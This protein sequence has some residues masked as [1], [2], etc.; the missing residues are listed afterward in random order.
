MALS[1]RIDAE[2]GIVVVTTTGAP[3]NEE[4]QAFYRRLGA[5]VALPRPLRLLDDRRGLTRT[6]DTQQVRRSSELAAE[7]GTQLEGARIAVVVPRAAAYGM[8]RMFQAYT[9]KLPFELDAF[10]ELEPA[11]VWLEH[12][13]RVGTPDG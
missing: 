9:D 3:T 6:A 13:D 7:L 4:Q 5:D 10:F 1:Y 12:G 8:A 11:L 2:L